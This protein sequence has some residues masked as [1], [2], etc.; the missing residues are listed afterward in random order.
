MSFLS[1]LRRAPD[2]LAKPLS[3]PLLQ[4]CSPPATQL[5]LAP[6][7]CEA[8]SAWES[9]WANASDAWA[10]KTEGRETGKRRRE[11]GREGARRE[12][13]GNVRNICSGSTESCKTLRWFYLL[14]NGNLSLYS[15]LCNSLFTS[16][17]A[18]I[19]SHG[20][21][22]RGIYFFIFLS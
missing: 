7:C 21:E 18:K 12:R 2:L 19:F 5:A 4:I 16:D 9:M 1:S 17:Y 3:F 20:W 15:D 6:P 10:V 13:R 8:R 14:S 22:V 11:K